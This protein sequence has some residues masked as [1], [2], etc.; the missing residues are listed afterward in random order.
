[1]FD[2]RL[3]F[4]WWKFGRFLSPQVGKRTNRAMMVHIAV[5]FA[6]TAVI[7]VML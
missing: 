6:V 2:L 4:G 3:R 1:M 7:A 5:E